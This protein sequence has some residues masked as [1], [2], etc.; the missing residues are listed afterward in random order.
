MLRRVRPRLAIAVACAVLVS[1]C[2][3]STTI[4]SSIAEAD[5]DDAMTDDGPTGSA[6]DAEVPGST[7]GTGVTT[8][9]SADSAPSGDP[10]ES[11]TGTTAAPATGAGAVDDRLPDGWIGHDVGVLSVALPDGWATMTNPAE[12]DPVI[13][14][15]EATGAAFDATTIREFRDLLDTGEALIALGDGGDNVNAFRQYGLASSLGHHELLVEELELQFR[16]FADNVAFTSEPRRFN[17]MPG[18]LVRGSYEVEGQRIFLY[19]FTTHEGTHLYFVT[20]TLFTG[21]DPAL[22]T[23]L[24]RNF[25]LG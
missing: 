23:D 5:A 1:S 2:S 4:T 13:A 15:A 12:I 9:A 8:A 3:G 25:A 6:A 18:V 20:L 16:A 24:F 22:A 10:S 14:A 21:D 17:G 7:D 19:Q 11:T